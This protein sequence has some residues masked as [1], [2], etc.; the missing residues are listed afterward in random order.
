LGEQY[1]YDDATGLRTSAMPFLSGAA[2]TSYGARREFFY[3]AHGRVVKET[4][5]DGAGHEYASR[6]E[7]YDAT[8]LPTAAVDRLGVRTTAAYDDRG[9]PVSTS[10]AGV[11]TAHR[12]PTELRT[13]SV[14]T[15]A[16]DGRSIEAAEDRD[17]SGRVTRAS[18]TV[19]DAAGAPTDTTV[20]EYAYSGRTTLVAVTRN[21]V[22][23]A[24]S[25]TADALGRPVEEV[26]PDGTVTTY[27][28]ECDAWAGDGGGPI[29]QDDVAAVSADAPQGA[30][31]GGQGGQDD[32]APDAAGPPNAQ[33]PSTHRV[34]KTVS[35]GGASLVTVETRNVLGQVLEVRGPEEG[36]SVSYAY[37]G[38]GNVTAIETTAGGR[39][40]M[41]TRAYDALGRLVSGTDPETGTTTYSGHG[42]H[43][44]PA[45]VEEP[46][47]RAPAHRPPKEPEDIV[48]LGHFD[49]DVPILDP[50]DPPGGG[51]GG[52]GGGQQP[53]PGGGD[54]PPGDAQ[55]P[56]GPGDPNDP[57]PQGPAIRRVRETTYDA[58][59]RPASV[60]TGT[61]TGA[62]AV[63]YGPDGLGYTYLA[64][65]PLLAEAVRLQASGAVTQRHHHDA[66][67]RLRIERTLDPAAPAAELAELKVEYSYDAWG[68]VA[69]VLYPGGPPSEGGIEVLYGNDPGGFAR[70][71]SVRR[72]RT[73]APEPLASLAPDPLGRR[74][75]TLFGSGASNECAYDADGISMW[76]VSPVG[77][78]Q[79]RHVFS[80]DA[81]GRIS[82]TGEWEL[83]NDAAGRLLRAQGHGV[84]TLHG[85]DGFGNSVAHGAAAAP[86]P[87]SAPPPSTMAGWELPPHD[88]KNR[89]PPETLGGAQTW[90]QYADNGEALW[91]GGS[92]G[93]GRLQLAWDGLGM[94]SAVLDGGTAYAYSYAPS[95]LRASEAGAEAGA[96]SGGRRFAY[97]AAGAL[98][99]VWGPSP[100]GQA[101]PRTD[102][103]YANGA[104]IA[105]MDGDGG[106]LE[107]HADH[108]GSP[109]YVTDG[110]GPAK[111]RVVG[112]QAFGPY[113]ERMEGAF[114]GGAMPWGRGPA[115]G[116]TGHINEDPTGLIYM[117]GRYYSP[118]WHRF[119]S[120]DRGADPNDLNQFAYAGGMPFSA[121]D[122]SGMAGGVRHRESLGGLDFWG[123]ESLELYMYRA[124]GL[125]IVEPGPSWNLMLQERRAQWQIA[126]EQRLAVARENLQNAVG[127]DP[128][129][130]VADVQ[131][132][133]EFPKWLSWLSWSAKILPYHVARVYV[134]EELDSEGNAIEKLYLMETVKEGLANTAGINP[135]TKEFLDALGFNDPQWHAPIRSITTG[136]LYALG[137]VWNAMRVMYVPFAWSPSGNYPTN[138]YGFVGFQ[139]FWIPFGPP[140]P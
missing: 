105:E 77:Q 27:A 90:W 19:R 13:V 26:A 107:L 40:Q 115:T 118:M 50:D 110:G 29:Y 74:G 126:C 58:F 140:L 11:T 138:C 116:Y 18:T 45:V 82:G 55:D 72:R 101:P 57:A 25:A 84:L 6:V 88:T 120:S 78:A 54:P 75:L 65:R 112:E 103:I 121:T 24:S 95:G 89:V 76:R 33:A 32:Q 136:Y 41:R 31:Q 97:T 49:Q 64:D 102:V 106:V 81:L 9:R 8:G 15:A 73:L 132:P 14:T 35:R 56:G 130:K 28:Y 71:V 66:L 21:G 63:A 43:G 131:K 85:R 23:L 16:G 122:P 113:G 42:V 38:L 30:P 3:D 114:P 1:G 46:L 91:V 59:G 129:T 94:L 123:M 100:Q 98:L 12:Y 96:A 61:R 53:P 2:G 51:G 109:R 119:V 34:T 67:G 117:R 135:V 99:S 111:G 128:V 87:G 60:R 139:N 83:E 108:L 17:W 69:G 52:G 134:S 79:I 4:A 68:H 80:R 5:S 104:A 62:G 124:F 20:T 133:L 48:P 70:T 47:G 36:R 10:S 93:G 137:E 127:G 125:E 7:S 37:D 22:R 44:L 86:G 39:A 92:P